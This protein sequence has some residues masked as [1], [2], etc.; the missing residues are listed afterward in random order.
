M[1]TT[2]FFISQYIEGSSFN[3]AIELYN[4]TGG[5][6]DLSDFVI[7]R[8]SNGGTDI[9]ATITLSGTLAADTNPPPSNLRAAAG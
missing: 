5:A 6:L 2:G 3:K 4:N 8:I 7:G 1:P 9:E